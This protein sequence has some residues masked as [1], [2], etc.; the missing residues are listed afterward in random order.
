VSEWSNCPRG[1]EG[2]TKTDFIFAGGV[3]SMLE[4]KQDEREVPMCTSG[5][6]HSLPFLRILVTV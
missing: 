5:M 4:K 6:E 2:V 1:E 3:G